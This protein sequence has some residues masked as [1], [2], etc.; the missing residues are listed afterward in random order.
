MTKIT[1]AP[2]LIKTVV[3]EYFINGLGYMKIASKYS[4]S[5]DTIR[6]RVKKAQL[7]RLPVELT[8]F[9]MESNY[10]VDITD[11]VKEHSTPN[12]DTSESFEFTI[13]GLII[14]AA[15]KTLRAIIEVLKNV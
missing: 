4:L 12:E 14:K 13:Q 3:D 8:N 9:D 1:Y 5:R 7:S 2:E 15:K 6:G 11:F 10:V